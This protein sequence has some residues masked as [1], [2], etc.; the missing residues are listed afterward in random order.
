M[1]NLTV[2]LGKIFFGKSY[3]KADSYT[4]C[5]TNAG[6][7]QSLKLRNLRYYNMPLSRSSAVGD[8][9]KQG[10]GWMTI[11]EKKLKKPGKNTFTRNVIISPNLKTSVCDD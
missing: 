3:I 4:R 8:S 7:R 1:F 6:Q 11:S 5:Q 2:N 9:W 10:N